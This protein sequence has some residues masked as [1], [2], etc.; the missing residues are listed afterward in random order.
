MVKD[1]K[2]NAGIQRELGK[3]AR[4]ETQRG[5]HGRERQKTAR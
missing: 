1:T 2:K 5:D 4:G 3:N